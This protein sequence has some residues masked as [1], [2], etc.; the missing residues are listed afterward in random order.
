MT[1]TPPRPDNIDPPVIADPDAPTYT[2]CNSQ[3]TMFRVSKCN[4]CVNRTDE[5]FTKCSITQLDINLMI[6][7][8]QLACPEGYW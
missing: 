2:S 4:T 1:D 8:N 3:T 7:A 5:E 6:S